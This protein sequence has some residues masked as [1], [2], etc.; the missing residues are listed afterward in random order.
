MTGKLKIEGLTEIQIAELKKVFEDEGISTQEV[1]R[2]QKPS[3]AAGKTQYYEPGLANLII[4]LA[5]TVFPAIVGLIAG[6]IAKGRT[7]KKKG[8]I[9]FLLSKDGISYEK[10][11]ETEID[12]KSV[13]V[14]SLKKDLETKLGL[15]K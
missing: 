13:D 6:W 12:E 8:K 4:D 3:A 11:Y 1:M 5:P 7:I 14:V 15:K 10:E 2:I 9:K